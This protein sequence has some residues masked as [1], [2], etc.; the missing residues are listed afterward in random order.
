[1]TDKNKVCQILMLEDMEHDVLLIKRIVKK[2]L[3]NSVFTV[4][5]NKAEFLEKTDWLVPQLVLSD[6]NIPGYNGLDA[7]EY[8][9]KR[10]PHIPFIFVTGTLN[11]EVQAAKTILRGASGYVLKDDLEELPSLIDKALADSHEKFMTIENDRRKL[12]QISINLQKVKAMLQESHPAGEA[13][14]EILTLMQ[15]LEEILAF[16]QPQPKA[17]V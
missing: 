13:K 14:S 16:S 1:M 9:H 17:T 11:D 15:E 12:R 7:M 5:S 8:L 6:I 4:A 2:H 3:P 10:H